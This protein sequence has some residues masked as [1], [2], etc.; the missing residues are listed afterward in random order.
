MP[1]IVCWFIQS[2]RDPEQILRLVRTLRRGSDGPI[3]LR[4]DDSVTPL[5]AA[6]ILAV[7]NVHL[8]PATGRQVRGQF[9]CGLQPYLNAIDW[10]ERRDIDYSHAIKGSPRTVTTADVPMLAHGRFHF[11]RKF[12][13]DV[14]REVL[15]I[16]DRDLLHQLPE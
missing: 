12:D 3:L 16:I 10:L 5:D 14:D 1:P 7:G 8:L 13:F 2:H 9:S 6:P 4:H 15:D 11:A